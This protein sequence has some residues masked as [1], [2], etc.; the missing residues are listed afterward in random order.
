MQF[1]FTKSQ[2]MAVRPVVHDLAQ[3]IVLD[4]KVS[5]RLHDDLTV[6]KVRTAVRKCREIHD[7]DPLGI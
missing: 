3:N 7:L 2:S 4:R 1:W 5:V 6:R